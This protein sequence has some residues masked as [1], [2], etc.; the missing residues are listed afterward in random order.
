MVEIVII[1]VD[2]FLCSSAS[3]PGA[4]RAVKHTL[5]M[6]VYKHVNND[7]DRSVLV[8]YCMLQLMIIINV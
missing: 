2:A 5:V 7:D 8:G 1:F 6:Y 4:F 3:D